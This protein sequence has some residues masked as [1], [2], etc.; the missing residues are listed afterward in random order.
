MAGAPHQRG[1]V[2]P[3]PRGAVLQVTTRAIE[4]ADGQTVVVR[5][6]LLD[7]RDRAQH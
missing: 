5:P 3:L 4:L 6:P 7:D 2:T 1:P